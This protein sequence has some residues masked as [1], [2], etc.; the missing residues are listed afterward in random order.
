VPAQHHILVPEHQKLGVLRLITAEHQ[1]S[2]TEYPAHQQVCDL[3]LHLASQPS[4]RQ[5]RS[6]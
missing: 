1:D 4:Q 5:A 2:Q 6:Q 3:E